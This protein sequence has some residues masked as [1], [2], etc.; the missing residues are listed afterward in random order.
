[1][2]RRRALMARG[3]KRPRRAWRRWLWLALALVVVGNLPLRF[4]LRLKLGVVSLLEPLLRG[5]RV[6]DGAVR[7]WAEPLRRQEDLIAEAARL[8]AETAEHWALRV[9]IEELDQENARL[10]ALL[11]MPERADGERVVAQVL[12][13]DARSWWSSLVIGHGEDRGLVPGLAVVTPAG[14]VG[15]TTSVGAT[16]AQV[17]LLVDQTCKIAAMVQRTRAAGILEGASASPAGLRCRMRFIERG[18]DVRAGD[19]VITSG[20]GS[21]FP[22]GILIGRIETVEMPDHGLYQEAWVMPAAD[23][24]DLEEVVVLRD[25]GGSAVEAEER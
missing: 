24:S 7:E 5:S 12:A 20:L 9:Q 10:R 16:A 4:S 13:R 1:V 21:L 19:L 15:R 25:R 23:L 3:G 18:A 11:E 14:M 2:G 22:K 17:L 8:R 6:V